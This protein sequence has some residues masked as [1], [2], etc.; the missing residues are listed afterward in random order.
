MNRSLPVVVAALVALF[1]L[2]AAAPAPAAEAYARALEAYRAG[3]ARLAAETLEA[4]VEPDA[5]TLT[6]L[7]WARLR[8]GRLDA[9]A[10]SFSAA[11]ERGG[12]PAGPRTGLG[13]VAL[14]RDEPAAAR[15]HFSA[16]L[17]HSE[18][19]A[20]AWKGLALAERA[21][22]DLS[23]ARTALEQ[24]SHWAPDDAET[25]R[26]IEQV[27]AALRPAA[28]RRLRPAADPESPLHLPARAGARRF[29][30]REGDGW[31]PIFVKGV[32]LG[33]ALPGRWPAEFP[34]DPALYREW[35]RQIDA[36]GANVVRLYTLHP[37][38]LYRA[39]R[40]HN[41]KSPERT[42]WIV[43]GVWTELPPGDDYGDPS[44]RDGFDAEIRRVIDAVHGNLEL[45]PRPG[46]AHGL[47]D[48]DVSDYV[49]AWLIG[50]EWEPYSVDG[51]DRL[52][53]DR[54]EH[55]GRFVTTSGA[56]PTE[57]W[58]TSVLD[59]VA[60]Y[61]TLTH[62]AQRPLGF[63]SWPTLDPLH[64]PT[65]STAEEEWAIQGKQ[66]DLTSRD[67]RL[68]DEDRV[69]VDATRLCATA[70]FPAGIFAAYHAYPYYPDFMY[71]DPRFGRVREDGTIARYLGYLEAL[72]AHHGE[73]PLLIAEF[74]VPSSRG[75]AH[76]HPEGQ[77]HG[78]HTTAAQGEI[79]AA[80]LRDIHRAGLAGGIVFAWIDEWFKRNW[81]VYN[82]EAPPERNPLWLNALDPEQNY[83]LIAA[84]PGAAG[85]EVVLDG[86]RDDWSGVAPLYEDAS[87]T[88]PLRSLRAGADAA[89]LYLALELGVSAR[90]PD[91]ERSAI[92]IGLDSYDAT[93]GDR[94]F[95][96]PPGVATTIGMEF[97][98]RL[99]GREDSKL[100]IDPPYRIY[101]G[102][103]LRPCRSKPNADGLF[104]E[105][106]AVPNRERFGRDGTHYPAQIYSRSP[107][108][109]GTT[110]A[111]A[112]DFDSLADWFASPDGRFIEL[113]LAW[114]LLHVTDPSSH[115]VVHEE[116]RTRGIVETRETEGF[117]F[118]V[119]A[120]ERP[121]VGADWRVV[122]ALP[123]GNP[124][125]L[126]AF[127]L[128]RWPGW[129]QP[130]FHLVP[131]QS[132][133]ILQRVL[134]TLD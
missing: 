103:S 126:S 12:A 99:E 73:L 1:C 93:R 15:A 65:E 44:F 9:A 108:R 120:L 56:T 88:A 91:G 79:D 123:A 87:A 89:Y 58:L 76:L 49:L 47:Y 106:V 52:R 81:A 122:A 77:H 36:M 127:P 128:F 39:L 68:H 72:A 16:A 29:E 80:L 38:S 3:D 8:L 62:R 130:A 86:L 31:K 57:A 34:D 42:L 71:L 113:R 95:P 17:E 133:Y 48:S 124:P 25:A 94:R 60:E 55:A 107:L 51:Y 131:K 20:E 70:A 112:A 61:E 74:G 26:L 96:D 32:N 63:V 46:H 27:D 30:V 118:H 111:Q 18:T 24:A 115:R 75:I 19:D 33:T 23:A 53:P 37:P 84:W 101:E 85:P 105:I 125:P 97:L 43:Q 102:D 121:E 54:T 129:E 116:T 134:P 45:P 78:G 13:F 66:V 92:W 41:L 35:L 110:A 2:R 40:E 28:E 114:G 22:G 67:G 11:L 98:I 90:P 10:L 21:L 4:V 6:L 50:R 117:R 59:S 109:Y 104:T 5:A 119:L 7:G 82:R 64:H 100:L 132:Y 69:A 14:R 83:G